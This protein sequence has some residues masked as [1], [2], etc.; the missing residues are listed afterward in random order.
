MTHIV[1]LDLSLTSAGIAVLSTDSPARGSA[2]CYPTLLRCVGEAGRKDDDY[3]TRSRR[4]R[5]QTRAVVDTIENAVTGH[6]TKA[7]PSTITLAVI[8]GPIYGMQM[9]GAYFDRAALFHG[10]YGALDARNI[11]IA[12]IPPT[13][14][15]QFT[16]GVAHADKKLIVAE[17]S[18][19]WPDVRIANDDIADALGYALMGAMRLGLR[20]PFRAGARHHNAIASASWPF[21]APRRAGLIGVGRGANG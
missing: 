3:R 18:K 5:R 13:T 9:L 14:G 10:V 15:H 2:G 11:P 1:G 20:P 7:F 12:V 8:E 16:T 6:G 19:W 21:A 4:I 17:V